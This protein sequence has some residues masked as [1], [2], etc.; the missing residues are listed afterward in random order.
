MVTVG[1]SEGIDLALRVCVSPGDEVLVPDPGYV[2][3]APCVTFA[4]GVPVPVRT[5]A[6]DDFRM[7]AEELEKRITPKT[8]MLIF[9]F[10]NNPTGAVMKK[11]HLQ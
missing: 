10:P 6:K 2:S 3:Y 11:E 5:Y 4:G 7:T 1:G 8:K 9:P